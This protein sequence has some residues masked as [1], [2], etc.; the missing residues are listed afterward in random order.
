MAWQSVHAVTVMD[1]FKIQNVN[2]VLNAGALGFV[3]GEPGEDMHTWLI[4]DAKESL[5]FCVSH[6][7]PTGSRKAEPSWGWERKRI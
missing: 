1:I 2:V 4:V 6:S 5:K 7:E 3:S